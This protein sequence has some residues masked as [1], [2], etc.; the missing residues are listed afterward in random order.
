MNTYESFRVDRRDDGVAVITIDRED[1][2]NAMTVTFFRELPRL[3][4][5]LDADDGVGAAVITGAGDEAFSAGGDI[6]SFAEMHSIAEYRRRLRIVYDA[7]HA[8]ERSEVPVVAAVNGIAYGGGTELTLAC[9]LA[10]ASERARFAF[11]E[12]TV[13]LMPGYGVIRGPAVIGTQ[14]TRY[15]ALTADPIDGALAERI[16]LVLKAVPHD[17]VLDEA[18]AIAARIASRAPLAVRLAKQFINRDQMAPGQ[19]ESIE[20]TALLFATADHAEGVQAFLEK[21]SPTFKGR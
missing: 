20:A 1:K 14:W 13:G 8:V 2:R 19:P 21:R 4:D 11:R 18:I 9:D 7:F 3:L 15:L 12:P 16:G 5:D 10:V 17:Q 6:A